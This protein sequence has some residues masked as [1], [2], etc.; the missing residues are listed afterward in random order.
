M[1]QFRRRSIDYGDGSAPLVTLTQRGSQLKT[2]AILPWLLALAIA[3]CLAAQ[4][5]AQDATQA[6]DN[7]PPVKQATALGRIVVTATRIGEPA[8]EVPADISVVS[9]DELTARGASTM[10]T[11]LSLVPGVEA[12]AGG[13]AGPSSTV[14]SFWGLHEFDAFLL[15]VD[16]APWGGAFNPMITTLDFNDVQRVEVLKGAAPVMFGATSFVGVVQ[17]L[18]YPAGEAANLVNIAY[19][20]HGSWSGAASLALPQSGDYRQSIAVDGQ[21]LG[22]SDKRESV[23]SR[24]VMYRGALSL[25]DS[26]LTVDANVSIVRDTPPSPVNRDGTALSSA[27]PN[28]ANFNPADAKINQD[29]YHFALGYSRNTEWGMWDSLVSTTHS[30]ITDVR[31]F[32]HPDL[33]GAADTQNQKR[34]IDDDYLDTHLAHQFGADWTLVIGADALFGHGRQITL[35]S[36]SGYNVPLDGS[37]LPPPT[38]ALPVTEI[39]TVNDHR[40]FLGQYAQVDW[41]PD[42]QW[43]VVAG[44]RLNETYER[45]FASDLVAPDPRL[46]ESHHRNVVKPAETLGVSDRFWKSGVDE[47][48]IYAD[49]RNGF[50]PAA[51]DFGPDYQPNVLLP[52][53]AQSFEGGI[54]GATVHGRLTYGAELFLQ[55]LNNVV[56]A[57]SS[58]FLTNAAKTQLKGAELD[59]R[60]QVTSN[61]ALAGTYAYHDANFVQYL[62]FDANSGTNVDVA[63]K[64]NP[65]SPHVLASAGILYMPKTGFYFT[66]VENYVGRRYL[67]EENTAPVAGFTTLAATIG[68][69]MGRYTLSFEGTNLTNRRP[70]VTAS[71]FGSQSFYLLNGRSGWLKLSYCLDQRGCGGESGSE[72]DER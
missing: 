6:D 70:P 57:T 2:I 59:A 53:T 54:K 20:N 15:V 14:P 9:G 69:R 34:W 21:N 64:Q 3:Q 40:N 18:H 49:Y 27:I 5:F 41:K 60:F 58:G 71:E 10:A 8:D 48:V 7:Q 47:V 35:N 44:L 61:L 29:Q 22:F 38:S 28:D 72:T 30:N 51:I 46:S 42:D 50:K 63:G 37:V 62:F 11:A 4:A 17:V 25:D 36:N 32:L 65:F 19:G 45:K 24:Q 33:S 1:T 55:N 43:D 13:D 67:D 23:S 39:G 56:V 12:P 16:G 52:E 66:L 26:K 68:Y 31:A